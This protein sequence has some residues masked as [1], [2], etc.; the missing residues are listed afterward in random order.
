[1][2]RG[3]YNILIETSKDMQLANTKGMHSWKNFIATG[4]EGFTKKKRKARDWV[5][6]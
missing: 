3:N 6:A 1:M 4:K 2:M 5:V